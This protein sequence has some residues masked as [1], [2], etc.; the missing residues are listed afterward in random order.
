AGIG[1]RLETQTEAANGPWAL[2]ALAA[3]AHSAVQ[4]AGGPVFLLG[5]RLQDRLAGV[6][7]PRL[8]GPGFPALPA[9]RAVEAQGPVHV[10]GQVLHEGLDAGDAAVFVEGDAFARLPDDIPPQAEVRAV[11]PCFVG[12]GRR[13]QHLLHRLVGEEAFAA[14][15]VESGEETD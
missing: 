15:A 1:G 11:L 2:L 4:V 6:G 7:L 12:R 5:D 8:V 3:R 10:A 9:A 13:R 14:A